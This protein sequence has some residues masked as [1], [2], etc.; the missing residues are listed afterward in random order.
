MRHSYESNRLLNYQNML[1]YLIAWLKLKAYKCNIT[2]ENLVS[3]IINVMLV[4]IQCQIGQ[5]LLLVL[6]GDFM[7]QGY[8]IY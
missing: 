2:S 8:L 3:V 6:A 7:V 5:N 1:S 4:K